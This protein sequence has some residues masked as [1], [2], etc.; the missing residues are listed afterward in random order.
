MLKS[1]Y[2]GKITS[3]HCNRPKYMAW[4]SSLVGVL[5][6]HGELALAM[7]DDFGLETAVGVQLD[8]IGALVGAD[9]KLPFSPSSGS[10]YLS[11][12]NYRRYIKSKI[13]FNNWNGTNETLPSLWQAAYPRINMTYVDGMDGTMTVTLTGDVS[14]LMQEMIQAGI[15][16]PVPAGIRLVY[17]IQTVSIPTYDIKANTGLFESAQATF[18]EQ[19]ES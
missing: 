16:I 13:L 8:V 12:A 1:D 18:P 11:D 17:V 3:A 19:A 10:A 6:D 2:L 15:L 9:R 14:A 5:V 7:P 4:L